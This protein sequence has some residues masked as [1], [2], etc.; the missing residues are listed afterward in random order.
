[1]PASVI[2]R[3]QFVPSDNCRALALDTVLWITPDEARFNG[4]SDPVDATGGLSQPEGRTGDLIQ[5][6]STHLAVG[7]KITSERHPRGFHL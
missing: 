4:L 2:L 5:T 3:D 6:L 1:M 7:R